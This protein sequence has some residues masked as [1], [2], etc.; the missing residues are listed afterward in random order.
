MMVCL[1]TSH[2]FATHNR[3]PSTSGTLCCMQSAMAERA[4]HPTVLEKF[5]IEDVSMVCWA[6]TTL[7]MCHCVEPGADEI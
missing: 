4:M 2:L 6:Y 5:N 1:A 3:T 7:G